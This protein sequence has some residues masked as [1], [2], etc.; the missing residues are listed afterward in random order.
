MADLK[1][2]NAA[3]LEEKRVEELRASGLEVGP[4]SPQDHEKTPFP[5][6]DEFE[7]MPGEMENEQRFTRVVNPFLPD[8]KTTF[9]R[10]FYICYL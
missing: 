7:V 5:R 8:C 4:P 10:I 9:S 2:V 6:R 3:K 1:K